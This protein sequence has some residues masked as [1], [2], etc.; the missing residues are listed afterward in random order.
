[1]ATPPIQPHGTNTLFQTDN[2]GALF[3]SKRKPTPFWSKCLLIV[4]PKPNR[5]KLLSQNN[6]RKSCPSENL[7]FSRSGLEPKRDFPFVVN[8]GPDKPKTSR[9][10]R[11]NP[12][13]ETRDLSGLGTSEG[14]GGADASEE[15]DG[16][17]ANGGSDTRKHFEWFGF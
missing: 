7:N 16:E 14:G 5:S 11:D 9:R 1:M 2:G 6:A 15:G 3:S 17:C 10:Q 4:C 8:G 13:G 12:T